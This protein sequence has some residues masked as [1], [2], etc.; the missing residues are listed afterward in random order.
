MFADNPDESWE[1]L[2]KTDPYYGVLTDPRFRRAN[3]GED[4][5]REFFASG[6][7]HM[8]DLLQRIEAQLGPMGRGAALDFG[9]GVGRLALR[10]AREGGFARVVGLDISDSMLHEARSNAAHEQPL[11]IEFL[12]SDDALSLLAGEFDFVHS[13]IVLQPIPI[14]RGERIVHHLLTRLAPGGVAALQVPFA[15][16]VSAVGDFASGLGGCAS[17]RCTCSPT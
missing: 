1:K 3:L 10:L 15:R 7:A 5:R 17:N 14:S 16:H 6:T 12:K 11:N 13:F 2:G 9:C 4:A 8:R